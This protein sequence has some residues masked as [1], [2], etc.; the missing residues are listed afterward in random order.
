MRINPVKENELVTLRLDG[1]LEDFK[2]YLNE[3]I[4]LP[5]DRNQWPNPRFIREA[6]RFRRIPV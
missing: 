1:G 2:V 5:Q 3:R 4:H 6:N